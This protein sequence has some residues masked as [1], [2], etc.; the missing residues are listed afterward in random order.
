MERY[1]WKA[2]IKRG[3]EKEYIKRHN[4]IWPEMVKV[5]KKAGICNY[6]IWLDNQVVFGYYECKKGIEYAVKIQNSS[7]VVEKWN[8]FMKDVMIME[9]DSKK[10]SQPKLNQVFYL[11]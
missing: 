11:K 9:F 6:S 7:P 2:T 1:A 8:E 10:E 5:L 3:K 4:E